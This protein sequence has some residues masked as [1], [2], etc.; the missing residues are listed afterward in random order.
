MKYKYK[1]WQ[2]GKPLNIPK[3]IKN[4]IYEN[5]LSFDDFIKYDLEEKVP[6]SCLNFLDRQIVTKFGIDKSK[7]LDWE[8]IR[9]LSLAQN[10]L[11]FI[12][13]NVLDVNKSC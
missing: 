12:E 1:K 8:L 7:T 5:K 4:M 3:E 6:I 11:L 13:P 2:I 9:N 10:K